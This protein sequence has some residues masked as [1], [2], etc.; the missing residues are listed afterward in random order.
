MM[1]L[2]RLNKRLLNCKTRF[3]KSLFVFIG[4]S[5]LTLPSQGAVRKPLPQKNKLPITP[6]SFCSGQEGLV[7]KVKQPIQDEFSLLCQAGQP[8]ALFMTMVTSAYDGSNAVNY[9][10]IKVG[11]SGELPGWVDVKVAYSLRVRK[12]AVQILRSEEALM[13]PDFPYKSPDLNISFK[14]DVAPV[15]EG[16]AD[17]AFTVKQRSLRQAGSRNFDDLSTHT[18]KLYR[19][20]PNNFDF[21][22]AARSLVEDSVELNKSERLFKKATVLRAAMTDPK[23]PSFGIVTTVMNFVVSDQQGQQDRVEDIFV[24]FIKA[25]LLNVFKYHS[26][27]KSP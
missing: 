10:P 18:L 21:L 24:N 19:L 5:L 17:T 6:V 3:F 23:D 27:T 20:I 16:D 2:L 8:T 13:G 12:T 25:D 15:L 22:L 9:T 7:K 1:Y 11:P 26:T 4:I 14:F